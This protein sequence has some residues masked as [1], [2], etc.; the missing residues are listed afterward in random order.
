M[1]FEYHFKAATRFSQEQI[2]GGYRPTWKLSH[3]HADFRDRLLLRTP[4]IRIFGRISSSTH[5][6][7]IFREVA[8]QV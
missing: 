3:A 8:C 1:E 5:K 2:I 7:S 4:Y 6:Y